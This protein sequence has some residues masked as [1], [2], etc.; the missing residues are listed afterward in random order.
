MTDI[1]STT[2]TAYLKGRQIHENIRLIKA[3]IQ[4]RNKGTPPSV[5]VALDAKKAFDSVRHEHIR[6]ILSK[7]GL[8]E[9]IPIFNLLYNQLECD[10]SLN[11]SICRGY[12]I[13]NGV[14]QGDALS[15]ILFILAMEPLL[16]SIENNPRI[17][18]IYN[19]SIDYKWPKTF[20]YADDINILTTNDPK[21]I[22]EIFKE[23]EKFSHLSGLM[24]NADKTEIFSSEVGIE[25]NYDVQYMG[26]RHQIKTIATINLNGV[27]ITT[28]LNEMRKTNT[29]Q[30]LQKIEN[31][32]QGWTIRGLSL[33]G[34]IQIIKTFGISQTLFKSSSIDLGTEAH[35]QIRSLIYKFLWGKS[36]QGNKAPDRISRVKITADMQL[37]GLGLVDHEHI[38]QSINAKQTLNSLSDNFYHPIGQLL[39]KIHNGSYYNP[40][41]KQGFDCTIEKGL[42][43]IKKIRTSDILKLRPDQIEADNVLLSNIHN[44]AVT[45]ICKNR[46]AIPIRVLEL[47]GIH[48]IRQISLTDL[49]L[50]KP[51]LEEHTKKIFE[52]YKKLRVEGQNF[53]TNAR[54][55]LLPIGKERRYKESITIKSKE[56]RQA[57]SELN[58]RVIESKLP[59]NADEDALKS[60]FKKVKQLTSTRHKNTLLRVYHGDIYC[61][62]RMKR[63][64]LTESEQCPNCGAIETREHLLLQCPPTY[65]MWKQLTLATENSDTPTLSTVIGVRDKLPL[66]K[67]KSEILGILLRK[68]RV[69]I[70][71]IL[72]VKMACA[73]LKIDKN[74]GLKRTIANLSRKLNFTV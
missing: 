31:Q 56:I 59:L 27:T 50:M 15:C 52:I 4:S 26:G 6:K 12:R 47:R 64:G 10:I 46:R 7:I 73:R 70:Q 1:L 20:C 53:D 16:R 67:I 23:Y 39:R 60:F 42:E 2:Q 13:N 38:C 21:C 36:L 61:H 22:K 40:K 24:L 58:A 72:P 28:N 41:I 35:A 57:L 32:L 43:I 44:E 37:G 65:A 8:E 3:S 18:N 68:E 29:D 14:K 19:L 69:E 17:K 63:M 62:E 45:S 51:E 33:L 48:K 34:K 9:F 30:I 66:I 11:G 71:G 25:R 49:N 74:K 54:Q 55:S 5:I